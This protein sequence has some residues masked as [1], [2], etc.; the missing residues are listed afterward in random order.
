MFS[1]PR[2]RYQ[3]DFENERRW[4]SLDLLHG[5]VGRDHPLYRHL[6]GAGIGESTLLALRDEPCPSDV[7]GVNYY[8]T[9]DRYLDDRRERY[10]ASCHGGNG[11][12]SY[13]DVEA[14][15]ARPRGIAGHHAVLAEAWARR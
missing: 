5:R 2:L 4:L 9:S 8:V 3:A 12:D 6:R 7:I 11:R 10:P 1:S 13:A 14:V 15:R